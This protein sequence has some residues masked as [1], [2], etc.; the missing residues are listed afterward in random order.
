MQAKHLNPAWKV[1][2]P[3]VLAFL[4]LFVFFAALMPDASAAP[5]DNAYQTLP[6]FQD[7]SN[8][9]LITVDND[10]AG[11]PGI[12]GYRGDDLTTGTGTDPQTIL[13]DGTTTPVNVMANRLNPNT[14]TTGGVAEFEIA[15]SVV[16]LQGSG[17]ADAPFILIH[18][19][20][21][22]QSNIQVSYNLRDI[23]GSADNAVQQVALHYRVGNSGNFTNIPEG[24]VADATTGPN[25]A[26]LVTPVSVILPPDANN[27]PLV[28]L[29]I[30]TTN[31]P[32]ADEWV[33]IDDIVIQSLPPTPNLSLSK[34]ADPDY[35]VAPQ[36]LVTYQIV[37]ANIGDADD[38]LV[39]LTDTLPAQVQFAY[40]LE[41][42]T[43]AAI[44]ANELTWSGP[45][46]ASTA[47]TFTFVVT[48][49]VDNGQVVNTVTAVGS[50][51]NRTATATYL[52]LPAFPITDAFTV[53]RLGS[54]MGS[55]SEIAA[56][57]SVSQTLYVVTGGSFMEILDIN[58]PANPSL[59]F[60]I[61]ITPYG[62]GANSVAVYDGIVAVAVEAITKTLPGEV[63]FFDRSGSYL[64]QVTVGALPDMLTY[65]PDGQKILVANEG[66]PDGAI[67]PEG[68]VSVIDMSNGVAGATVVTLG[69]THFTTDTIHPDVRIF[70]GKT[71]AEDVEPE[72]IAVSPD[73]LT[74]WVSLQEANALAIVD[75][76]AMTITTILPLGFKDHSLSGNA[77][78]PSDRDGPGNGPAINIGNWPVFGMYMPDAIAVYVVDGIPYL[79]TANEGDAR[80][81]EI[82]VNNAAYVLDP[83]VFPNAATLKLNSNLGRLTVSAIDGD[84]DDDGDYD[85]IYTYGARSFSIWNG[86]TGNL[87]YDSGSEL[88]ELTALFVPQYFNTNNGTEAD[89]DT[90]SD[91]KGPEPEGIAKGVVNGRLYVFVGL[92][93]TGGV[94]IYD[95]TD[96][97]APFFAYYIAPQDL[98]SNGVQDDISPEGVLFIDSANSPTGFP[99]LVVSHEQNGS[100]V[101]YQLT[102]DVDVSV[103]ATGP[104]LGFGNETVTYAVELRNNSTAVAA[105]F[106]FTNTFSAGL[107]Y[108]SDD[109]GIVPDNPA[110]GVY[111]WHLGDVPPDFAL[112]VNLTA[113]VAGNLANGTPVTSTAVVSSSSPDDNP[114]NN[115]AV[116]TTNIY[117]V[118]PIANAR[119]GS[120][121][122]IFALEGQVIATNNTW[123]NAPEWAFQD[124]SGGIAAFFIPATPIALGDTLRMV[125]T[126]GSFNNQEQMVAPVL[127]LDVLGP[128][129]PVAPIT[130]TTGAVASGVSEGWLVEIEGVVGNMP[131]T[132]GTAYNITLNDG[133]GPATVRIESATGINLCNLGIQNGDMLGVVGFSTQFQTTF[134]VK[135]R[136]VADLRLFVDNPF[137]LQ[138]TPLNNATNVLTDTLITIQ[139]SEPVTVTSNWFTINCSISGAIN[140]SSTPAGPTNIY[141]LTPAAPFAFGEI[142]SVA[143]LAN[144]VTNG[145]GLNMLTD[146]RFSFT[147]GPAP[148]FGACGNTAVP[149]HFIQGSG[150]TT[151][152]FG[153]T[154]VVE[155]VVVGS[156][157][158]TGQFNGFFLQERDERVDG[159]PATSEG[160]FVFGSALQTV[161]PGDLVRVRGTAA[162]FNNLTQV[163]SVTNLAVCAS[164]QSVTPAQVTLPVSSMMDWEA[165]EGMLL[166]FTQELVVTEH[167]N[168]ARFGELVLSVNDRLWAPTNLVAPGVPALALQDLNNR[169]RIMLDDGLN[170]QNPA[171]VIYPDPGLT[172]TNTLRTGAVV[173]ALTGVLDYR[174][175]NYRIQP[176]GTVLFENTAVR[177]QMPDVVSGTVRI[178]SFNVLNYFTTLDTGAPICGPAQNMGCRGANTPFEFERQRAKILNTL[179]AID[180]D[181]VGLIEIE[182]HV[183]DEAL[184][185]LVAGLNDLAGAGTYAY[186]NTGVIGTDAI[187]LAFIYKPAT[188][189][190]FGSY[191]IL[192]SSVDP[193]FLDTKNRPTLIQ[194]FEEN[195]TGERV[196]V[197][198]SHLK[199]K[200]SACDDVGDPD[201]GDGQGNC[202]LTRL[203]AAQALAD[204]L[205]TDP[206]GSGTNRYLVI[207][208][209]NSYAMEDPIM[210]LTGVGYTDLL[211]FFYGDEAYTY[212]FSG[213]AGHL[214][215]VLASAS[216]L[217]MVTGATA[218]HTNA[219]EPRALDYNTEF[220]SAQQIL[221]WYSPEPFRASDHDPVIVGLAM[222]TIVTPTVTI[223]TPTNGEVFTSTDGTAVTIPVLITTTDFIIPTDGHW[224][225]LL[226]GV[227]QG[228]VLAYD[229]TVELLPGVYAIGAE[230]YTLDHVSLGIMDTVTVTVVVPVVPPTPT[231]TI[232][233]PTNG[234]V[235]TSTDGTAVTIPVLITTTDFIIPTDGHWHL[236]LNGV[237]QGA[238]LAYDTTVELLPGVY[239]IGAE[240]Y[241][242]D[243]VSLGLMDTVT[244]TVV[245][246][247]E[248]GFALYLPLIIKPTTPEAA[249]PAAPV[250]P[251]AAVPPAWL[252]TMF[253]GLPMLVLGLPLGRRTN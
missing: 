5:E 35:G 207:G 84:I 212:V 19:D 139:F 42:P 187:K 211:R 221:E 30:M 246:A 136:S 63:V 128:G 199:S 196:T 148:A 126:R 51:N 94:V 40:W 61:P 172:Y 125:A 66:E 18:I 134:Q 230:L 150:A 101:I 229:T 153:T 178:A 121:G 9:S 102:H 75:I 201:V 104:A 69:F 93:R 238:V 219:D 210:A 122:Q 250:A 143:V 45:I 177:P 166:S 237:D 21:T 195:S 191:V 149:I 141:T 167:Y 59:L 193:R 248:E 54:F 64:G 164:G 253:V 140:A 80:L 217:P 129:A 156:Y 163:A 243:D 57:D 154:V 41:Q 72:Y 28:Q 215:H 4:L 33:G 240:L 117:T 124:A 22:G 47:I 67:D 170:V 198:V 152:I 37:A 6:F 179:L 218:W 227:D 32:G 96:P 110:P 235:F 119:A 36:E 142:C 88:E 65:T 202:N 31:A 133:S 50:V 25:L 24:Y 169:S 14:L 34:T 175:N 43:G 151:P 132:C 180:A 81:E 181:V 232:L 58:D 105:N 183:A 71:V 203:G 236:L 226:N 38:P 131:A 76:Q 44:V 123:N 190:P 161:S 86:S 145:A 49:L 206:T 1:I 46:S 2:T 97:Q 3:L 68:S 182:N 113:T 60:T 146:Y 147:V 11:V 223:V 216:L 127:Y 225:L 103:T 52:A 16:A 242:P 157:Q 100:T 213:Q 118:V 55:G 186:V 26:E 251:A 89:F 168:L 231:V 174:A 144:Q 158:G 8:T 130:Y 233:V 17:T 27:Q 188:V 56:H 214:D 171:T 83:T 239:A 108:L 160:I 220:K 208:D 109:S 247:E 95:I 204:Y 184:I 111:V 77:F 15:D 197:A 249:V 224:H 116:V 87:V 7:W 228:A 20:T 53:Q 112:T 209:M 74:A 115:T 107:S 48:N 162:E 106:T 138:T 13:V 252:T 79:L 23:D 173:P 241:T 222:Y 114:A 185:D 73:G 90:R 135:P 245:L 137:V 39:T 98:D 82:R 176:V 159:D 192:D 244:V 99:L 12:T 78:D 29:R 234:E 200:G 194:T 205:A 155:A 165:V 85:A 10:W 70:P 120:N 62:A 189:T 91:N 92:E